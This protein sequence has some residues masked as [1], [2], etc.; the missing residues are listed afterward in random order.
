[1]PWQLT[2]PL[3]AG[4]LDPE[5][6]YTQV[7]IVGFQ[8]YSNRN[9]LTVFLEYGNT[10]GGVWIKGVS[11]TSAQKSVTLTGQ[12]CIDF[13]AANQTVYDSVASILYSWLQSEGA[14]GGGSVV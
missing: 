5:G 3:S 14:I 12:D 9:V 13:I 11:P 2:T 4:D 10:V 6:P 8:F 7:K 1:M